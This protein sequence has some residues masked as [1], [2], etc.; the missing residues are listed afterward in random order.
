MD[1]IHWMLPTGSHLRKAV[2]LT[3]ICSPFTA[4]SQ[5]T[6]QSFTLDRAMRTASER[7]KLSELARR[8]IT[9]AR[10]KSDIA[11][12][13]K[14]PNIALNGSY[15]RITNLTEWHDNYHQ[16]VHY[17]TI[18]EMY[19]ATSSISLP[20][21][22]GNKLRN[23]KKL[24]ELE[25]VS[26]EIESE[27]IK[28]DLQLEVATQF[29]SLYKL[30]QLQGF[31]DMALKE[32]RVRLKETQSLYKHGSVT[33]NEV[34]RAQL[35]ISQRR[36]DS[37]TNRSNMGILEDRLRILV[38]L[39]ESEHFIAD[40]TSM[41]SDRNELLHLDENL[42]RNH[43][44][45]LAENQEKI[46]EIHTKIAKADYFPTISLFG[47]Y[48]L[49]YP[50]TLF[51]PQDPFPYTLGQI[52]LQF[53]FSITDAWRN[54]KNVSIARENQV[55]AE[56]GRQEIGDSQKH[57]LFELS[58]QYSEMDKNLILSAEAVNFAKDNYRIV[59]A[60]YRQQ[61]VLITEMTDADNALIEARYRHASNKANLILKRIE[62][63]HLKG[64]L[65]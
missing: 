18:P 35:A 26:A 8:D 21:Y 25:L 63:E 3:A 45:A 58:S 53:H 14:L 10:R 1:L 51:F 60:K 12:E 20:V 15:S 16:G 59:S 30:L 39:P 13:K 47:N 32:E 2:L 44:L 56:I 38:E 57:R 61:M 33:R 40:T 37:L 28:S 29:L 24:G 22:S 42:S 34:L 54:R 41:Y 36:Q 43:E 9:I 27:K 48:G 64:K 11:S 19:E 23:E 46:S 4:V 49:R 17:H 50:N 65:Q 5:R 7:H 6:D 55:K 31:L 52:G 62:I